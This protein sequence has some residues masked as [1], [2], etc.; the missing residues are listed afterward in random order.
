M[1]EIEREQERQKV[2]AINI[3]DI[4]R[5]IIERKRGREKERKREREKERKREREKERKREREKERERE[6][7]RERS[8]K[9]IVGV[10][11]G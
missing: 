1:I 11:K 4:N 10:E 6:R 7:E 9:E 5:V 2:E 8:E 3:I